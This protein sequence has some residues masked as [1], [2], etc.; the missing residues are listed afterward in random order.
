[1][2]RST[3]I[4]R[5][6]LW[7]PSLVLFVPWLP[8]VCRAQTARV[9]TP[10]DSSQCDS[11]VAA[12]RVD[13]VEVGFFVSAG[14]ID[15]EMRREQTSMLQAVIGTA[16]IPPRPFRLT[17]FSGDA[18][19]RFFRVDG[20]SAV[21]R[22]PKV[23]GV[24]RVY[25]TKPGKMV[26]IVIVRASLMP[27]FDSAAASAIR[28]A[29][30]TD[31]VLSVPESDDSMVV[32]VSFST[33]STLEARRLATAWFPR[34]PLVDARPM[35]SNPPFRLPDEAKQEG[36]ENGDIVLRFVVGRNGEPTPGTVELVRGR[37]L[38]L[39]RAAVAAL[40]TQR[41]SPA[42]IHGCAVAQTIDYAFN[43]LSL[44]PPPKD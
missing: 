18:R 41:F 32:E 5:G 20:D 35:P 28:A 14:R 40:P 34:M 22:S 3:R 36:I 38:A 8:A 6:L 10:P 17:V 12:A 44:E 15:G 23:R 4:G 42:T 19:P 9:T 13:S 31:D 25:L 43:F 39:L 30:V 33:D 26:R 16:F 11:V 24:Y 2:R 27:G 1:M 21:L 37:S 7:L 29:G